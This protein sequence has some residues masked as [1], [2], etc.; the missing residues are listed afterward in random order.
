M[1][2]LTMP[3]SLYREIDHSEYHYALNEE[4][5]RHIYFPSDSYSGRVFSCEYVKV[6]IID[7][8]WAKI[9]FKRNYA[10]NGPTGLPKCL[11]NPDLIISTL[12]HDGLYQLIQLRKM[13]MHL[14]GASDKA[15][16][17]VMLER[18]MYEWVAY[19]FYWLVRSLGWWFASPA[20]IA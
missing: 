1:R 16:L 9:T 10:W 7:R 8:Q 6:E 5:S 17:K 13:P 11:H 19:P 3:E 14:R 2:E 18:N 20:R 15:F 12:C 4:L